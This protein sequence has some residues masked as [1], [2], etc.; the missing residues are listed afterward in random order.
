MREPVAPGVRIGMR[1]EFWA[2]P[3]KPQPG[4]LTGS[5]YCEDA[6]LAAAELRPRDYVSTS[7]IT[8]FGEGSPSGTPEAT[9]HAWLL[10]AV[11]VPFMRVHHV[12]HYVV[13]LDCDGTATRFPAVQV[14]FRLP[15]VW[16]EGRDALTVALTA[17]GWTVD[18]LADEK[19][20]TARIYGP[21]SGR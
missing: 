19:E 21:Q 6:Y 3:D 5:A 16:P 18:G 20:A 15:A 10:R 9:C 12:E 4:E 2:N 7:F 8:D 11:P 17:K 1:L 13:L 14:V